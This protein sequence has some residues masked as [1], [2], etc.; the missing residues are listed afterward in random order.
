MFEGR[1]ELPVGACVDQLGWAVD[2]GDVLGLS[3][4]KVAEEFLKRDIED[5][6]AMLSNL[7]GDR[8]KTHSD[9]L[10]TGRTT[11][12][13]DN[14]L[15]LRDLLLHGLE[16]SLDLFGGPLLLGSHRE[17]LRGSGREHEGLVMTR[18]IHQTGR[19]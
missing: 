19:F 15:G 7:Y 2:E 13:D 6:D 9:K 17:R 10:D 1:D 18:Q 3:A 5:Q 11:A 14:V 8:S 16:V 12:H 4:G